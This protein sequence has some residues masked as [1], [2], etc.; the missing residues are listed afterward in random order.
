M[1]KSV[2]YIEGAV[3]LTAYAL[4]AADGPVVFI[5]PGNPGHHEK[6]DNLFSI[7][8]GAGLA[9]AAMKIGLAGYPTLSLPTTGKI[10]TALSMQAM[11]DIYRAMGAGYS[12]LL[13]VRE[14]KAYAASKAKPTKDK[15]KIAK[16]TEE[17]WYFK[18]D[19]AHCP[20]KQPSFWGGVDKTP[21]E[22]LAAQYIDYLD[23]LAQFAIDLNEKSEKDALQTIPPVF[24]KAYLAGKAMNQANDPW[25]RPAPKRKQVVGD[26]SDYL[27][28]IQHA[29]ANA[30]AN[31]SDWYKAYQAGTRHEYRGLEGIFSWFRHGQT[32]QTRAENFVGKIYGIKRSDL[33]ERA[34][35][36]LLKNNTTRYNN[37]SFASFLLHELSQVEGSPWDEIEPSATDRHKYIKNDVI[38]HL[39]PQRR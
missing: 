10:S 27:E 31:Y 13:P 32:G 12:I 7:K 20:G 24:R 19:L 38:E 3:D 26:E 15:L 4:K 28:A 39:R 14:H 25:L 33:A 29:V 16:P 6:D 11:C 36:T 22:Q 37:H 18:K 1:V 23:N 17:T 34:I 5:F 8:G 35:N 9:G 21:N 2:L 30:Q